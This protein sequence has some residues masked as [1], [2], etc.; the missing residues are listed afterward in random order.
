MP[1]RSPALDSG[2]VAA[3]AAIACVTDAISRA[4]LVS[5]A[6]PSRASFTAGSTS[7]RHGRVPNFLCA[8]ARPRTTPGIPAARGPMRLSCVGVPCASRY[9]SRLAADGAISR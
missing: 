8:A 1:S 2:T 9:M 4:W 7:S 3:K 5:S 6:Q